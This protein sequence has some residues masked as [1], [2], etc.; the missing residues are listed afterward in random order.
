VKSKAVVASFDRFIFSF[1]ASCKLTLKV[2][3]LLLSSAN[4]QKFGPVFYF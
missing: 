1:S 2:Q 3:V 4:K